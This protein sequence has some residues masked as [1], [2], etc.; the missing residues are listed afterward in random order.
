MSEGNAERLDEMRF[1]E[2][3]ATV[4]V[5][6]PLRRMDKEKNADAERAAEAEADAE[7]N[8]SRHR[9]EVTVGDA[10][11]KVQHTPKD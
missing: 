3:S 10:E 7:E 6:L 9:M 11:A 2:L 1:V 5:G 8:E 4:R